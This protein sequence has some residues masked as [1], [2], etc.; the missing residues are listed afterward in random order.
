MTEL[1]AHQAQCVAKIQEEFT[2]ANK[3]LIKM[4]CGAG[5]SYIIFHTVLQYGNGLSII[6]EP[7]INLITQFHTDYLTNDKLKIYNQNNFNKKNQILRLIT[8]K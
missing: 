2:N 5:K 7:S 3:A 8:K 6:V 4:F 1:R